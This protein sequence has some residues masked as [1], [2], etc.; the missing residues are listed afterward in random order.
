MSE[1]TTGGQRIFANNVGLSVH[2]DPDWL[3]DSDDSRV[4]DEF[5]ITFHRA[6]DIGGWWVESSIPGAMSQGHSL[7]EAAVMGIEAVKLISEE[8]E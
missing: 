2:Y 7:E 3:M 8:D 4:P 5:T 6:H 1:E